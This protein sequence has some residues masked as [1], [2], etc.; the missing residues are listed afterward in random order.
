MQML[1]VVGSIKG[2]PGATSAALGMAARWPEG[3]AVLVEADSDGG[4]LAARFGAKPEPGL[5][6]LVLQIRADGPDE[7]ELVEF[8]QRLSLGADVVMAP[9]SD[10]AA[11][12]VEQF[13]AAAPVLQRAARDR[14]VIVDAGRLSRRSP[15]VPVV[16]AADHVVVV[17]TPELADLTQV[18]ARLQRLRAA[19]RGRVWV[20]LCGGGPYDEVEVR[21]DLDVAV[22]GAVG[23]DK[24]G[25]GVL[26]GRYVAAPGWWRAPMVRAVQDAAAL[27]AEPSHPAGHAEAQALAQAAGPAGVRPR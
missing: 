10:A 7:V 27:L 14:P 18:S 19:A 23:R 3:P 24:V 21:R 11:A 26:A 5:A 12:A 13:A 25:S 22:L 9:P 4:D 2:S 6:A 8:T 1:V 20:W 17:V 16:Q 15:L